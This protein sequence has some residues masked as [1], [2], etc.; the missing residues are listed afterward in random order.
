MR[1]Q[2]APSP[3]N[4]TTPSATPSLVSPPAGTAPSP[5]PFQTTVAPSSYPPPVDSSSTAVGKSDGR[6]DY[7][8]A[9]DPSLRGSNFTTRAY[10]PAPR[11]PETAPRPVALPGVD[12]QRRSADPGQRGT[13]QAVYS[14]V[15]DA[16]S[17]AFPEPKQESERSDTGE[18]QKQQ[19]PPEPRGGWNT[20]FS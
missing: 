19:H 2:P 17:T 10:D 3:T 6:P 5:V 20:S 9:I 7:S 14:R 4:N 12:P 18:Q 13:E 15:P 1:I 11:R 16:S 8:G